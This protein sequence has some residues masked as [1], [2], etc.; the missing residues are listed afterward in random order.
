MNF[1][2]AFETPQSYVTMLSDGLLLCRLYLKQNE[3]PQGDFLPAINPMPP[4]PAEILFL[5]LYDQLN[6]TMQ[7]IMVHAGSHT[8]MEELRC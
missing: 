8:A 3:K 1:T 4:E 2:N 6:G 7:W 5:F